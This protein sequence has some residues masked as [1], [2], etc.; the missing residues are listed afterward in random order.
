MK[1]NPYEAENVSDGLKT[2]GAFIKTYFRNSNDFS[3]NKFRETFQIN[4]GLRHK[5]SSPISVFN[6]ER[7]RTKSMKRSS[8]SN[9]HIKYKKKINEMNKINNFSPE[10]V[11]KIKNKLRENMIADNK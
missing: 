6:K 4:P 3:N 9:T 7:E 5:E 1:N 2:N 11:D 10:N 8:K